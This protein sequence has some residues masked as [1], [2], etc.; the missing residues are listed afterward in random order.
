MR[1]MHGDAILTCA[2]QTYVQLQNVLFP[3]ASNQSVFVVFAVQIVQ[4]N[5]SA[6]F[7]KNL[8]PRS[9]LEASIKIDWDRLLAPANQIIVAMW[10]A[11]LVLILQ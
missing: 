7:L 2:S 10:S 8:A 5:P 3:V 9:V 6:I 1:W 4:V 11:H